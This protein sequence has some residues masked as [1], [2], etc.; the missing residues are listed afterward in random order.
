MPELPDVEVLR[1]YL[2]ATALHQP[3]ARLQVA[4]PG[5]LRGTTPQGL[6]QA[7]HDAAFASSARHG[8]SLFAL[9]DNGGCL[10]LHFGMSGALRYF[11]HAA[12]PPPHTGCLLVFANDSRLAYV[13]PRKLGRIALADSVAG[14]VDARNLGP[15]ALALDWEAF[16]RLARLRR[17]AVK[18]WLMNQ[19][20]LAG[21]GNLYSDEI[22]FQSGVHP[23]CPL[24]DL[25]RDR[26]RRLHHALHSVL[27][28]AIDAGADPQRMP[29]SF[30]LPHRRPDGH[31]PQCEAALE[32]TGIA[33]RS[34]WFC[35]RCQAE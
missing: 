22:L 27:H 32:A 15:D 17:G 5:L 16:E 11:R 29:A 8:K 1:R 19:Q 31:C 13:A 7:L 4:S 23:R 25:D 2:D 6:G 18:S 24:T 26:L 9:L 3:I 34:A 10:V 12:R 35:P 28:T 14:F 33:G 20:V 21:I 30:F